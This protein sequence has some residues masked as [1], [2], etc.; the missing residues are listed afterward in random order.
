MKRKKHILY[1][2]KPK[3]K[4]HDLVWWGSERIETKITRRKEIIEK[5]NKERKEQN[6]VSNDFLEKRIRHKKGMI[7]CLLINLTIDLLIL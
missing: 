4:Y 3:K 2:A 5:K 1:K 7:D 6:K